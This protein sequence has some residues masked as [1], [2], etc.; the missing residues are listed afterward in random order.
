MQSKADEQPPEAAPPMKLL[1]LPS[2]LL[3]HTAGMLCAREYYDFSLAT[4]ECRV[5]AKAVERLVVRNEV[6]R[7]LALPRGRVSNVLCRKLPHMVVPASVE[8]I[9]EKAFYDCTSLLSLQ[10]PGVKK[11]GDLAFFD[12]LSL[13]SVRFSPKLYSVGLSLIHI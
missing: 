5:A 10:A 7:R 8:C 12:C 1:D 4:R 9:G 2:A 13:T 11:L 3:E 6:V